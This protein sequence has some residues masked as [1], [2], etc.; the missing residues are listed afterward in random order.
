M[1][2]KQFNYFIVF[3][4]I[5]VFCNFFHLFNF[6]I[7]P[8]RKFSIIPNL[9]VEMNIY[10]FLIPCLLLFI[11]HKNLIIKVDKVIF[12][13][14]FLFIYYLGKEYLYTNNLYFL[15]LTNPNAII[16]I[17]FI[18]LIVGYFLI[19]LIIKNIEPEKIYLSLKISFILFSFLLIFYFISTEMFFSIFIDG[20]NYILYDFIIKINIYEYIRSMSLLFREQPTFTS[21]SILYAYA[22]LFF[23]I[24]EYSKYQKQKIF[25]FIIYFLVSCIYLSYSNSRSGSIILIL[26]S[27]YFFYNVYNSKLYRLALLIFLPLLILFT[28]T[29]SVKNFSQ[30]F[31]LIKISYNI[32]HNINNFDKYTFNKEEIKKTNPLIKSYG[33]I[34][35]NISRIGSIYQIFKAL[36]NDK[37]KL[38]FG[39]TAKE[40]FEA[41][42]LNYSNHSL[43]IYL[44]SIFGLPIFLLSICFLFYLIGIEK[45]KKNQIIFLL[46]FLIIVLLVHEKIYSYYSIVIYFLLNKNINLGKLNEKN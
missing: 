46:T 17:N 28:F 22:I 29:Q 45:L 43:L 39:M 38:I 4:L 26:A 41:K 6:F 23:S 11:I 5:I 7:F 44:G 32:I 33:E 35:S 40:A 25:F 19:N 1:Y 21:N 10:F 2:S 8:I 15:D 12:Y 13:F 34:E 18:N 27:I 31:N 36:F 37:K 24:F 20:N 30:N 3:L 42:A 9:V 14:L 16:T